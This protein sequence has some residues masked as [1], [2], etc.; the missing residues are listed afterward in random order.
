M[1]KTCKK[2]Y[3][4]SHQSQTKVLSSRIER[5][6]SSSE[7]VIGSMQKYPSPQRSIAFI[8]S[9]NKKYNR[10]LPLELNQQEHI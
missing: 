7:N 10:I 8:G 1:M 9:G 4:P 5:I 3:S 6:R 2:N